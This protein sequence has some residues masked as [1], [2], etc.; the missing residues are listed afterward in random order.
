MDGSDEFNRILSAVPSDSPLTEYLS[1]FARLHEEFLVFYSFA[2]DKTIKR[3]HYTRGQFWSIVKRAL[4]VLVQNGLTHKDCHVHYFSGNSLIDLA[5]RMASVILG[6]IP[7]TINWQADTLEQVMYKISVSGS[8]LV[9]VDSDTPH[10]DSIRTSYPHCTIISADSILS[11]S[12]DIDVYDLVTKNEAMTNDD[13]RCLIFTSGTT[14]KPKGVELTYNNYRTN[15]R[16]FESFLEL[17]DEN[18]KFEPIVVNPMHHTNS[19]SITDWALRRP[20]TCLH[21]LERYTTQYWNILT[22]IHD[23]AAIRRTKRPRNSDSVDASSSLLT[24]AAV[25]V[26]APL[27]SRHIDFLETYMESA[28]TSDAQKELLSS[29]L[30]KTVLLLGS[31]PVGPTTCSRLMKYGGHLPTVRFGS[32]ETTLQVC[33]I[34]LSLPDDVAMSAFRQGWQHSY[35]G[36]ACEGFYIGRDHFPHTEVDIVLSVR[37]S[38]PDYMKVFSITFSCLLVSCS[39]CGSPAARANLDIL[40]REEDTYLNLM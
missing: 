11:A 38:E 5:L 33:G 9:V 15:R 14:G 39:Y 35:N 23:N 40:L 26:V 8:R 28:G 17:T 32:T 37:Q 12:E 36:N 6:T 24:A 19:T 20:G 3:A 2:S 16:T 25:I 31:A 29:C 34:P 7:V 1:S 10:I 27:V 22:D 30:K 4:F 13:T 21:L 18:T